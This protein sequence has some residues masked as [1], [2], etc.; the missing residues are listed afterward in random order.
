MVQSTKGYIILDCHFKTHIGWV[1]GVEFLQETGHKRAQ[2]AKSFIRK[3][4]NDLNAKPGKPS[5]VIT[6]ATTMLMGIVLTGIC[7]PCENCALGK[8]KCYIGKKAVVHSTI[9]GQKLF[10]DM[11][12]PLTPTFGG[13]KIGC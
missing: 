7:R 5:E 6:H 3:D 13:K 12:S 10:F 4:I 2:L 1:A 9:L 11:S 8:A